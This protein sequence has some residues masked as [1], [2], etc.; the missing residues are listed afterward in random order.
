MVK[1]FIQEEDIAIV[2]IWPPKI[3]A[4]RYLQQ[5]L[6]DKKG[7]SDGNTIIVG[8]I[9]TPLISMD[10]SSRRKINKATGNL[11]DTREELDLIDIFRTSHPKKSEYAFFSSAHRNTQRLI[12]YWGAK[13]TTTNLRVQKLFQVSSLTTMA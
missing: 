9:N 1:G 8:D 7:E 3:E 6:T 11:N 5:I 12:S 10:R 2:H 13:L 4:P